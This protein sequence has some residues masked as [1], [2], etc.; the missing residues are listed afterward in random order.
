MSKINSFAL[1]LIIA[2]TL[3]SCADNKAKNLY[4]TWRVESIKPTRPNPPLENYI[5]A[6][7]PMMKYLQRITYNSDGTSAETVGPRTDKGSWEFGKSGKFLYVTSETRGTMRY[8]VTEMT[9][10]RFSYQMLNGP[11]TLVF[12]WVPFSAKDTLVKPAMPQPQPRAAAPQEQEQPEGDQNG[13][14]QTQAHDAP[15]GPKGA[16]QPAPVKK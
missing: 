12:T 3:S 10:D 16:P 7:I 2:I 9:K 4:N 1:V 5:A 6:Q 11:D 13:Q 8:I 15:A 14:Q